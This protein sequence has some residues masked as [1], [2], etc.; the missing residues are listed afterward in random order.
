MTDCVQI[1]SK[2]AQRLRAIDHGSIADCIE[3]ALAS[4]YVPVNSGRDAAVYFRDTDEAQ[5]ATEAANKLCASLSAEL[6]AERHL[7]IV[8][9]SKYLEL[10]ERLRTVTHAFSRDVMTD[11]PDNM[12]KRT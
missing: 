1:L 9:E 11:E 3:M 4:S 6:A 10:K 7:R 12:G 2:I 5:R 8:A